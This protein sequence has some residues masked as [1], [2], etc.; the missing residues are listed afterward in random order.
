MKKYQNFGEFWNQYS[1]RSV[2][3]RLS[4]LTSLPVEEKQDLI[5]S[6]FHEKW[7]DLITQN[8]V[9]ERLDCIKKLFG[10]DLIDMRIQVLKKK[11]FLVKK[12]IWDQIEQFIMEF[13]GVYNT[14][15]IFGGLKVSSCKNSD[16]FYVIT[17]EWR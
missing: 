17:P 4:Y 10:I 1:N 8:F 2:Q 5:D 3:D 6:F 16:K 11:S 13:E 15:I 14:D 9:D 12:E 7:C